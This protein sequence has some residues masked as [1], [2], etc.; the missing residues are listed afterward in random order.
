LKEQQAFEPN[1][2][3][4]GIRAMSQTGF[5]PS[6][7]LRYIERVQ[8]ADTPLR[9]RRILLPLRSVRL[10]HLKGEIS[11][12]APREYFYHREEW[13]EIQTL[14]SNLTQA[15]PDKPRAPPTLMRNPR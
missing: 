15:E 13:E 2:D 9:E 12:L 8:P 14:T 1:A 3:S 4:E 11:R 5:D 7:L 10:S 6:A